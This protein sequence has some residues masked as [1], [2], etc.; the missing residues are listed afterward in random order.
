[1]RRKN[2]SI[3]LGA[4]VGTILKQEGGVPQKSK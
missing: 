2:R 3:I 4:S 1:M